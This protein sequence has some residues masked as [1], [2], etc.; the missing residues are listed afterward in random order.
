MKGTVNAV[1]DVLDRLFVEGVWLDGY[2]VVV[3][4]GQDFRNMLLPQR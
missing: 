2:H 3:V 1:V 4:L